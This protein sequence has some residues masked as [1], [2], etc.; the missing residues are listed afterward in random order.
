M[1]IFGTGEKQIRLEKG[2]VHEGWTVIDI[3]HIHPGAQRGSHSFVFQKEA[4][5]VS[6]SNHYWAADRM[7]CSL[8]GNYGECPQEL[9]I[10]ACKDTKIAYETVSQPAP[11]GK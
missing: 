11:L 9:R 8:N 7:P 6:L 2:D 3:C 1:P 4:D 5:I 10:F